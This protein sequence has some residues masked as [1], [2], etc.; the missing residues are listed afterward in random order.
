M[1]ARFLQWV[2]AVTEKFSRGS[3]LVRFFP[4]LSIRR[5]GKKKSRLHGELGSSGSYDASV[6]GSF[7]GQ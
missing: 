4:D 5:K 3:L 2:T 1:G 7:T 6:T